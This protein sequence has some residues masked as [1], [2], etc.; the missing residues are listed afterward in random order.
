MTK[1]ALTGGLCSGK[2][3]VAAMLRARGVPVVDADALGHELLQGEARAEVLA[4]FGDT[5][6]GAGGRPDPARLAA[7]VFADPAALAAL[8]AILHP[9]IMAR[10][11]RELEREA[12][13]G[14]AVAAVEAALILEAGFERDFDQVW[15]VAAEEETRIARFVARSRGTREEARARM[16]R[17]WS[18]AEQRRRADV[19]IENNNGL[20]AT[21]RQVDAALTRLK[22]MQP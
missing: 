18:E 2:S 11:A 8:E 7:V 16:A 19:V 12:A 3:T 20:E 5:V 9:R 21:A 6:A 1:L 10:A 15:V 14:R 13:A 4:R 22:E 17:Q